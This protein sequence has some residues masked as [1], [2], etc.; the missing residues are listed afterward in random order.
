MS[1]N[2]S[3][4]SSNLFASIDMGTNSFKLLIVRAFPDGVFFP[5]HRRK[6]AVVL[7]RDAAAG[8][9]SPQSRARAMESLSSFAR[10]L[11]AHSVVPA[12]TACF[13]TS[14]VRE[15]ENRDEFVAAAKEALG[16]GFD[17]SVLS[18][19]E[20]AELAYKG[21]IQF[22]PVYEKLV[23]NVDIGG[24]S[25][26]FAIGKQGRVLYCASLKLGHVSLTQEF[27]R[28]GELL[29]L[30]EHIR[31]TILKSG[32]VDKVEHFGFEVAV[33]S[34]GTI[35]E[36]EE[37]EFHGF[38][39]D[40][41]D[42]MPPHGA[43]KRE[44]RLSRKG[45]TGIV[46]AL[47]HG[48]EEWRGKKDRLFGKRSEFIV[49]GAVLLGEIFEI[50]G[51]EEMEVSKYA[52]GE[53]AIADTLSKVYLGC[54]LNANVR[55]RS[56]VHFATRLNSKK[57]MRAAAQCAGI[58]REIF[59]GV[60]KEYELSTKDLEY[61]EAACLLHN[62]GLF[63][64]RKGYHKQSYHI[65]MNSDQL[66]G[67]EFQEVKMKSKFR[68]LC[69]IIRV[70]VALQQQDSPNYQKL[71]ILDAAEGLELLHSDIKDRNS[72][73][74]MIHPPEDPETEVLRH[75]LVNFRK[76]FNQDLA[77]MVMSGTAGCS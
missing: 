71:G 48:G 56:V 5:V 29:D 68:F 73:M 8:A 69:T 47:C 36:L 14:A 46:E 3:A 23:L 27:V 40:S 63:N 53:A 52:L 42:G 15:A 12:H 70:S 60:K 26:E 18:G 57:R 37:A 34:S 16:L 38:A 2:L 67:Y 30:R 35:R 13:A 19:E 7:G 44:W 21:V 33:G 66:H 54:D 4:P 43:V 74:E 31:S 32:L 76:V 25:T 9:I 6:E 51:I 49:A 72:L 58:A 45:L 65:I 62:T 17:V 39:W 59:E 75:E 41:F 55:W 10:I 1:S 50:L 20:E 64:G 28:H 24:G 22:L 11:Q 61:L 77:A